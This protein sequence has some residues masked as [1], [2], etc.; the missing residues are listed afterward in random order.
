MGAGLKQVI[1]SAVRAGVATA[2]RHRWPT[3]RRSLV[4]LMYHRVLPADD[5]RYRLEQPGMLVTPGTFA[6]HLAWIKRYF[7]PVELGDWV[8]GKART[9][10]RRPA[11]AVTFDDGWRD[12]HEHAF[13]L[14]R[15]AGVPATIFLVSDFIG[16]RR[17]FWPG[18][19]QRLFANG[20]S[21]LE[22]EDTSW[23]LGFARD[24]LADD[25]TASIGERSNAVI[26]GLK[27]LPDGEIEERLER[28]EA[29]A[30][31]G[32]A[33]SPVM[34][35]WEQIRA[36]LTDGTIDV[37]SHTRHHRRLDMGLD[38]TELSE[39]IVG[40]GRTIEEHTGRRPRIFCYPNGDRN[41][42]AERL[43]RGSYEGACLV[44]RGWNAPDTDPFELRRIGMHE[45]VART[46]SAFLSRASGVF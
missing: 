30:G 9:S 19:V 25:G 40:S 34:L 23:L 13:P 26:E 42:A 17:D 29:A 18:R 31:L 12:N 3:S 21:G 1:K 46:R 20:L 6:R 11:C 44:R 38:A 37:G 41:A 39:E 33:A 2:G 45:D 8:T 15:E 35:D 28:M 7:D 16:T 32:E 5:P 36:M 22:E 4:V 24:G 10:G 27:R 43:V 14:L